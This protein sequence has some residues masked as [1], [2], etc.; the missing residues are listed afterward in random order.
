LWMTYHVIHD[1]SSYDCKYF[2]L[3]LTRP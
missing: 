3:K 1:T 2:A